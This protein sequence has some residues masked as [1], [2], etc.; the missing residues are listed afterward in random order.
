MLLFLSHFDAVFP[1]IN[2]DEPIGFRTKGI[3]YSDSPRFD[4]VLGTLM[5]LVVR[6]AILRLP[7]SSPNPSS[8]CAEAET[9]NF[10]GEKLD[11]VLILAM[12]SSRFRLNCRISLRMDHV[13][14]LRFSQSRN[15]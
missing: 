3:P 14:R 10:F 1:T 5:A 2:R 12:S 9:K 15:V 8:R 11:V 7:T 6:I 4:I 13:E